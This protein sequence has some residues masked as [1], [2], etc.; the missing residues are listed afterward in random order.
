MQVSVD[1]ARGFLHHID[2]TA[3]RGSAEVAGDVWHS[4]FADPR[5][6]IA[7]RAAE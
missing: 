7:A 2:R 5:Q 3:I 6:K 4:G 1:T